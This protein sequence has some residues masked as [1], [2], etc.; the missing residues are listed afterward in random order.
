MDK[1]ND[2]GGEYK[3]GLDL[4][5]LSPE[6]LVRLAKLYS[7][8]YSA[9]D[10]FWYLALKEMHGNDAALKADMW[11]WDRLTQH[12]MKLITREFNIEGNDITTLL[13]ALQLSPWFQFVEVET[14]IESDT[15]ALF[16]VTRC[17][18]LEYMEREGEGREEQ[19]CGIMES[20]TL[21]AYAS[22]FNPDIRVECLQRPPGQQEPGICCR[23]RFHV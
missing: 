9:A 11:V 16:T 8:L 21:Q 6:A 22:Y 1:M 5:E 13:K 12:E 20:R 10:G 3:P 2:Y 17:K 7:R 19:I 14:K 4:A 18:T 15:S 23:W